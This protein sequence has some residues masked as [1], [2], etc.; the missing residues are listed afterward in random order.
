VDSEDR[1]EE[2]VEAFRGSTAVVLTGA[3]ISAPSGIPT[4]RGEDGIWGEGFERDQFHAD[5]LTRDPAEFWAD[6]IE[7][8]ERMRPD[9]LAPNAAHEALT[10]L[11]AAAVLSAVITQNIDGLHAA[12]GTEHVVEIH[13]SADRVACRDCGRREPA[14]PAFERARDGEL[15]PTC[16]CG[17]V[18]RPDVVLFGETLPRE[19]LT[20]ARRLA[21]E[22]DVFLAAGSSL[23]V[24]PAASLPATA[25]RDGE[26]WIC[27]LEPTPYDDGADGVIRGDV[28]E[29]LPGLADRVDGGHD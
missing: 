9:D 19:T 7:L 16:D 26:V 8:R 14:D 20:R 2:L 27:N 5:R 22:A 3:G 17:G 1:I 18:L 13:G 4:F 15:P 28:T 25:A 12:A 29:V 24:Q 11:E 6:R 10:R 23:S 21:D